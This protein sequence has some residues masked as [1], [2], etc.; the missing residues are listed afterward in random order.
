MT[1]P[2]VSV[3]IVTWNS[4]THLA[5]CLEALRSQSN[6][7][8]EVKIADNASVDGTVR[9]LEEHYP[10]FHLLRNTRNTGYSF[11][12]NQLLRITDPP[13]VL[14]LNPDV[15]LAP[16]WLER[17]VAVLDA[18][19]EYG[20]FGGKIKRF[21]YGPDELKEIER[22]DIIDSAG[23]K[24]F[25]SR[26]AIDRGSGQTDDGQFD[27]AQPVFGFS[28]A[29][30]MYRRAALDTVR[31]HNEFF[32]EDIFAYKDDVDLAWRLQRM[33]WTAWYDPQ[34]VAYHHRY[35]RGISAVSDRLLAK[36]ARR[37]NR[38]IAELSYRNH[39]FVLIKN[40]TWST[41]WRDAPFIGWYEAKKFVYLLF[42][43]PRALRGLAQV[44]GR[45]SRLRQKARLLTH[46]ARR[47]A[48]DVRREWFLS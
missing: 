10:Q 26:H 42:V 23:L 3:H 32:D 24:V 48:L 17:A 21:S 7:S 37:H 1:R 28:G 34:A 43:Q 16:D 31:W 8:F 44:I 13:Y 20:A 18:H 45:W 47:A 15:I 29:C 27:R 35:A 12:H 9:W 39:W 40:E 11:A 5:G 6:Q 33:G 2:N 4:L 25:R 30:V 36:N 38:R 46:H 14:I 41:V 22:S 19:P